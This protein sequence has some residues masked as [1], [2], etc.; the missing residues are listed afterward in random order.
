MGSNPVG[1][2]DRFF[3]LCSWQKSISS[4]SIHFSILKQSVRNV[5][6]LPANATFCAMVGMFI[7]TSEV[8]AD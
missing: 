4:L 3:A 5:S 6:H 8:F 2:S 7:F 1:D